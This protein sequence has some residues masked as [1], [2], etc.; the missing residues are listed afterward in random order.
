MNDEIVQPIE[1]IRLIRIF[2]IHCKS[3]FTVQGLFR[4]T[5]SPAVP[6]VRDEMIQ[7]LVDEYVRVVVSGSTSR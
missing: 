2:S 7:L 5:M 4:S 3:K 6:T 1:M